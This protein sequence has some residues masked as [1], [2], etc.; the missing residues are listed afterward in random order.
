[1]ADAEAPQLELPDPDVHIPYTIVSQ[2]QRETL[3]PPNQFVDVWEVTYRGPKGVM[4]HVSVP[5]HEYNLQSVNEA[6]QQ[7]LL[8]TEQVNALGAVP[9]PA[10]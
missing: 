8:A 3:I 4:G 10:E 6:I 1:V 5:A 7:Q 9:P 2:A